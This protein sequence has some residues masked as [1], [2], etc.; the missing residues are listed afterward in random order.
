M[1][2]TNVSEPKH[3]PWPARLQH[4]GGL[5]PPAPGEPQ[6][7]M[8]VD[9]KSKA[10]VPWEPRGRPSVPTPLCQ[11]PQ[12][13]G[14]RLALGG[15]EPCEVQ[16]MATGPHPPSSLGEWIG[17]KEKRG[18]GSGSRPGILTF[19]TPLPPHDAWKGDEP[20]GVKR[21]QGR[22]GRAPRMRLQGLSLLRG[23]TWS[24]PRPAHLQ[25]PVLT[26]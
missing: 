18:P 9:E 14:D 13:V 23:L 25:T 4:L 21:L 7:R 16:W 1:G 10:S 3:S 20:M 22:C 12:W 24:S 2:Q 11:G 19:T 26:S 8:G 17:S 5:S 15:A 6:G